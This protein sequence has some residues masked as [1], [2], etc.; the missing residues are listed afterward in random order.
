MEHPV[1]ELDTLVD[2]NE[3]ARQAGLPPLTPFRCALTAS[4]WDALRAGRAERSPADTFEQRVRSVVGSAATAL[5]RMLEKDGS[6]PA[7]ERARRM[8]FAAAAGLRSRGFRSILRLRAEDVGTPHMTVVIDGPQ[9]GCLRA[10]RRCM[11][12]SL[13][14]RGARPVAPGGPLQPGV[15]LRSRMAQAARPTSVLDTLRTTGRQR[16]D[17]LLRMLRGE[18]TRIL[19]VWSEPLGLERTASAVLV[20][21]LKLN[22]DRF[23]RLH[24]EDQPASSRQDVLQRLNTFR[25]HIVHISTHGA[26]DGRIALMNAR[27]GRI[28][29]L[30]KL[31]LAALIRGRPELRLLVLDA[32]YG[33]VGI[34]ALS[35]AVEHVVGVEGPVEEPYLVAFSLALY[36]AIGS[37][38]S[39][40]NAVAAA[41][42][43]AADWRE[44]D[45]G[46][47][48][49]S[50]PHASRARATE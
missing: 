16:W 33:L 30:D 12:R 5:A 31:E 1:Y 37:G 43:A 20:G 34:E 46:E 21:N 38:H 14:D 13:V 27:S 49:L 17:G 48:Q 32:C 22:L 24:Y 2:V 18:T 45:F 3:W 50:I 15:V 42:V 29:P 7:R 11:E 19:H 10:A 4:L 35:G 41:R 47:F 8:R 26:Q 36:E 39:I 25:P 9:G 40:P 23:P 28:S 6:D 44:R